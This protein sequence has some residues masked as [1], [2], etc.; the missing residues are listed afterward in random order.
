MQELGIKHPLLVSDHGIAATGL[1]DQEKALL[2]NDVPTFVDV[3][4]NPIE[5]APHQ[6]LALYRQNQC[7][8]VIAFGG[9]SPIDLAKGVA[10]LAPIPASSPN[11]PASSAASRASP[12]PSRR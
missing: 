3:P 10:L 8:G 5:S 6:A 1:L 12:P 2:G 7:D 11:M 9:G 4:T